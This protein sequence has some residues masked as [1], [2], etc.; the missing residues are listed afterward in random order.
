LE[1]S[2]QATIG[3]SDATLWTCGSNSAA[4]SAR[5]KNNPM[6]KFGLFVKIRDNAESAEVPRSVMPED[7]SRQFL[8][9][10]PYNY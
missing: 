10:C 5:K 3:G 1:R 8:Q 4:S 7:E 2:F 6:K 9:N